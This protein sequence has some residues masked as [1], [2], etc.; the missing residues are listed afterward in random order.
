MST[1]LKEGVIVKFVVFVSKTLIIIANGLE[2]VSAKV[3]ISK[4]LIIKD[5]LHFDFIDILF[6]LNNGCNVHY[7]SESKVK[8]FH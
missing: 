6:L 8:Q 5:L 7:Y 4:H 3:I 2:L 1:V